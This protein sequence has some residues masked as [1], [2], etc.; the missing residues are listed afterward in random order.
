MVW[1]IV[2]SLDPLSLST[3]IFLEKR[4]A[5]SYRIASPGPAGYGVQIN[6]PEYEPNQVFRNLEIS[7]KV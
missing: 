2:S 3:E 7:L 6:H 5:D 1:L 4:V